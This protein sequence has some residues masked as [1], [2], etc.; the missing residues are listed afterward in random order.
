MTHQKWFE[1]PQLSSH[2]GIDACSSSEVFVKKSAI[3]AKASIGENAR[4]RKTEQRCKMSTKSE[5]DW[6]S[7]KNS[8]IVI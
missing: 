5:G 1:E 8:G 7:Q 3:L 2:A 6:K 4:E